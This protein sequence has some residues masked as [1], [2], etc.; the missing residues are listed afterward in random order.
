M[1][2]A[3]GGE[4]EKRVVLEASYDPFGPLVGDRRESAPR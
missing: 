4:A 1:E 3:G 2:E